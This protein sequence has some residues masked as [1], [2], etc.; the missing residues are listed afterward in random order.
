M[1]ETVKFRVSVYH[2][3]TFALETACE[4]TQQETAEILREI[5]RCLER[6]EAARV[7]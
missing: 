4:Y 3:G 5:V 6:G 2:N 7:G 1:D